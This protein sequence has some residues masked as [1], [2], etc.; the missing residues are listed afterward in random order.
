LEKAWISVDRRGSVFGFFG[1]GPE[2]A[3]SRPYV[4]PSM[5]DALKGVRVGGE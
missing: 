4:L 2:A 3:P 5:V 1:M